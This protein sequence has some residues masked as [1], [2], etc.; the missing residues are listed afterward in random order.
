MQLLTISLKSILN[1]KKKSISLMV[2]VAVATIIALTSITINVSFALKTVDELRSF[3]PLLVLYTE[4]STNALSSWVGVSNIFALVI[5]SL[6]IL[7]CF[8]L[9]TFNM[10]KQFKNYTLMGATFAQT[11]IIV[12]V[13]NLILFLIGFIAGVV[14]SIVA[15]LIVG[16]ITSTVMVFA[17]SNIFI[18]LL[19]YLALVLI[20]SIVV[21]LW[22]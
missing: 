9:K 11:A 13:K 16:A 8:F 10:R 4:Q 1:E 14:L 21:P 5:S 19:I 15:S 12:T 17:V 2:A 20:I 7:G 6:M 22:S 18:C 3:I